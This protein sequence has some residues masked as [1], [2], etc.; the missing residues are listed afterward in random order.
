MSANSNV[1]PL[2]AR[3]SPMK[4]K[5][6]RRGS[7]YDLYPMPFFSKKTNS[8]WNVT[9]TGDYQADCETG[10]AY[11]IEF[12]RSCDGS[13]GWAALL[14]SITTDMI[15]AG[16][17][18]L[19]P[20]GDARSNGIVVGFMGTIGKALTGALADETF[21]ERFVSALE[22]INRIAPGSK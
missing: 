5:I 21:L 18:G 1:I 7:Q 16:P 9:P 17:D 6:L 19:W 10:R 3:R 20:G 11:A 13:F 8:T 12:L 22:Q 15:G 14:Q 4:G 2:T